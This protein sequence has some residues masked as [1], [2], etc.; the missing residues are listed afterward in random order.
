[1]TQVFDAGRHGRIRRPSSRP[2]RA[3]SCRRRRRRPTATRRCSSASSR[4]RRRKVEQA[5]G[6]P[7][8]EGRRAADARAPRGEAGHGRARR[9]RPATRCWRRIFANGERVDVDRHRAAA[10]A[11]RASCKRHHFAR[12]RRDARLDVPPRARLDRRL[13][14][15]LARRQ[16]HARGRPHGRR[17]RDDAQPEGPAG[18]SPR[19]TCSC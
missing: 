3:S 13:V 10:R 12:R 17:P 15:S 19:T 9:R 11:S 2:V 18:R 4:R 8:Q 1:M 14:V 7:L 6:R 5:A 16:G